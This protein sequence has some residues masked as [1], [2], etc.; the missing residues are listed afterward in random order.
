MQQFSYTV[1]SIHGLEDSLDDFES[2]C[3]EYYS[4]LL[5][6][7]YTSQSQPD[8]IENAVGM[9][10]NRFP[11]A[12][13]VGS[14]TSGE[15]YEGRSVIDKTMIAFQV[16]SD[17]RLSLRSIDVKTSHPKQA[18]K[19]FLSWAKEKENLVGVMLLCTAKSFNVYPFLEELSELPENVR[20]FG[21][22][23]DTYSLEE[24]SNVFSTDGVY[25]KGIIAVSFISEVLS[26]DMRSVWGWRPL[27]RKFHVTKMYGGTLIREFDN[28]PAISIY[29][30][31]LR[32]RPSDWF[33]RKVIEFPLM[34]ERNG[35]SLARVP[36]TFTEDGALIFAAD[37][38]EGEEV[39]LSYGDPMEIIK[40]CTYYCEVLKKFQPEAMM[41]FSC[42]TRR[43]FL[44][45]N[46]NLELGAY[47]NVAP[48]SG[49]YTHGEICRI[50]KTID[51][52][53]ATSVLAAFREGGIGEVENDPV[54]NLDDIIDSKLT[55]VQRLA[56]FIAM[57]STELET[58]N[59][60]LDSL[61]RHDR[62]TQLYNRGEIELN[63]KQEI[64]L[65]EK[66]SITLAIIMVDLD[67]FKS[68]NDT[69]GHDVGDDVLRAVADTL[70][71]YTRSIDIC[72]R[73]G[74][75][76]FLVVLPNADEAAV[77]SI[78][79]RIRV[80]LAKL[81]VLPDGKK[82]TGSFG[83]AEYRRG[84]NYKEF[85]RRLDAALYEAKTNGRNRVVLAK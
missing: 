14:T 63:L 43:I 25:T 4:A 39:R 1:K 57:I 75:E 5:I 78:A 67:H 17:T 65:L 22:G 76:E 36:I 27:G 60:Q 69:Y 33:S 26:I 15:I 51:I 45:E 82:V 47:Q 2:K 41:L 50:G 30:R 64:E 49:C 7:I 9:V 85:Y 37:F 20:V 3:P 32:I 72:G 62:L 42:V 59:Q 77:L 58:I 11:D 31:Y 8:K 16:F 70:Q 19:E 12:I 71:R 18:G 13:I 55:T 40:Q 53:N 10:A 61:A 34:V 68:I 52:F 84:E 29:E 48:T 73:W 66:G 24:S 35:K 80:N 6:T 79:E 46:V 21:G 23:A 56:H 28:V 74:G 54:Q 83:V 44:H 38:K 81:K